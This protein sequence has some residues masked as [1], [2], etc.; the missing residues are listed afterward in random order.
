MKQPNEITFGRRQISGFSRF[1]KNY[2]TEFAVSIALAIMVIILSLLSDKFLTGKNL[3]NVLYQIST[4]GIL[5][6]GQTMIIITGGID[7]SIGSIFELSGWMMASAMVSFGM[8]AGLIVGLVVAIACGVLNGV[9]VAY[10]K[11]NAFIVT[12]GTMSIFSG[13]VYIISNSRTIS[14]PDQLELFDNFKI[15]GL[16]VYVVILLL[17]LVAGGLFLTFTR[18]G[19]MLF[20]IGSN[21]ET[22]LYSGVNV[23][24]YTMYPYI[25]T[26][27][28][29]FVAA[30][31][32]GAHLMTLAPNAGTNL[33]MNSIAAVV[34]GG[35]SMNGGKGTM[36]G[37]AIGVLFMGLLRNGLNIL[38]ISTY[39]Q[40]VAVGI[41][42]ILAVSIEKSLRNKN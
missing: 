17:A 38:G 36:V 32:Q 29:V 25:F 3:M 16:P 9:L 1:K 8:P 13:L 28:F 27:F 14:P 4:I 7:L 15:L 18:P 6:V 35:V 12:L 20:A 33:N 23:K 30:L 39:W 5:A 26:G 24:K 34:I 10:L 41:I 31:V 40:S 19:R 2:G 21:E 42:I 11:I 22:A 37:T